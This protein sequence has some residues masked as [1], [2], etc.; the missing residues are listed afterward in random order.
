M[1]LH[2]DTHSPTPIR[3]P[4]AEP[5]TNV[6]E[7]GDLP[8]SPAL[9]SIPELLDSSEI[10]PNAVT[11]AIEDLKRSGYRPLSPV[12]RRCRRCPGAARDPARQGVDGEATAC[13]GGHNPVKEGES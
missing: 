2:L 8:R 12:R 3:R 9:P 10:T 6:F 1:D 11:R 4:G 7:G 13:P 5:L